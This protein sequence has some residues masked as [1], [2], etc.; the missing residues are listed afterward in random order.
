LRI[1]QAS[2]AKIISHYYGYYDARPCAQIASVFDDSQKATLKNFPACASYFD[3]TN[4]GQYV[5]VE[6]N[7]DGNGMEVAAALGLRFGAAG[8]LALSL[9]AVGVELYLRLSPAEHERL[10]NF[11]YQRQLEAG[12]K[13]PGRAGLTVDRFGDAEKWAPAGTV[14]AHELVTQGVKPAGSHSGDFE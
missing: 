11:S 12:M 13:N 4:P 6:A 3:G 9:H 1:I 14:M 7:M 2:S 8:W 10:R 5:V